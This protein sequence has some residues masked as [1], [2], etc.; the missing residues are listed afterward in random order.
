MES[1]EMIGWAGDACFL[2]SYFLVSQKKIEGDSK[3][4]NLMNL[5][6]A[7]LFGIYAIIKH[8]TPVLVLECFWSTIALIA[9]YK[10]YRD[11]TR[12]FWEALRADWGLD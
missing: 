10:A 3:S 9:L 8:T 11:S 4:F 7:V 12:E 2:L 1:V 6:G 5:A